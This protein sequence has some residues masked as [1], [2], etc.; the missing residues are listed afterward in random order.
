MIT[1]KM[2]VPFQAQRAGQIPQPRPAALV[3]DTAKDRGL[4]GRPFGDSLAGGS[5]EWPGRWP[6]MMP[7]A[8]L[9][10][11][12]AWALGTSGPLGR[13]SEGNSNSRP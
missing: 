1:R 9:P 11:P 5:C 7:V 12:V 13:K 2:S 6:W 10:R 8:K 3:H 4:K